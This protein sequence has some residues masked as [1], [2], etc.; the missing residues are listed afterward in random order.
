[1]AGASGHSG[2]RVVLSCRIWKLFPRLSG[3]TYSGEER[4]LRSV[5]CAMDVKSYFSNF[6]RQGTVTNKRLREL[7]E[8]RLLPRMFT[9]LSSWST[10]SE[11]TADCPFP[12]ST[13]SSAVTSVGMKGSSAGNIVFGRQR[14]CSGHLHPLLGAI[15]SAAR[16]RFQSAR[17][18]WEN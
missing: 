9:A 1:M 16:G 15:G 12:R 11:R 7:I 5:R 3:N 13:A 18:N 10:D 8:K 17:N 14:N 6:I 2:V 4:R